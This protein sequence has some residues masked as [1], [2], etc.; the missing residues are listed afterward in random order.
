[1]AS[2]AKIWRLLQESVEV[3]TTFQQIA[4]ELNSFGPR[5]DQARRIK[6]MLFRLPEAAFADLAEPTEVLEFLTRPSVARTVAPEDAALEKWAER[7]WRIDPDVVL[8][9]Y[10]DSDR[11]ASKLDLATVIVRAAE[12][13]SLSNVASRAPI[14]AGEILSLQ[15]GKQWWRSW[16]DL[17]V[18]DMVATLNAMSPGVIDEPTALLICTALLSMVSDNAE[19]VWK[20]LTSIDS[21]LAVRAIVDALGSDLGRVPS[22]RKNLKP[23]SGE[24]LEILSRHPTLAVLQVL[25]EVLEPEQ[26]VLRLGLRAW[27]GLDSPSAIRSLRRGAALL[28]LTGLNE[29]QPLGN[30]LFARIYLQLRARLADTAAKE[31]WSIL[32]KHLVGARDDWDRCKRLAKTV[33]KE[34]ELFGPD[35]EEF[36]KRIERVNRGAAV[37]LRSE[38]ES[39]ASGKKKFLGIELPW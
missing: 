3:E 9:L 29:P 14:L 16:A 25:V 32:S 10:L 33:A 2:L 34:T 20:T 15:H 13:I 36:L 6:R 23:H 17:P 8:D 26:R 4:I 11:N 1:L 27:K 38:A 37:Q 31:E 21:T 7:A 22:W 30:P 35:G 19:R 24:L 5:P 39:S 18:D 28:F 12:P